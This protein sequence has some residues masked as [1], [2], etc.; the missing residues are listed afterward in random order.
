MKHAKP[1]H[2]PRHDNLQRNV[3]VRQTQSCMGEVKIFHAC[4]DEIPDLLVLLASL[5]DVQYTCYV[6]FPVSLRSLC[7]TFNYV[8][9]IY[10][11]RC[12]LQ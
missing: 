11:R 12:S 2:F 9:H 4:L 1:A 8:P 3:C 7:N 5:Q 10:T 6:R